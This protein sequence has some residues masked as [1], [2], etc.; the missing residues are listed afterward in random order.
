V[1]ADLP[2]SQGPVSLEERLAPTYRYRGFNA[3]LLLVFAALALLLA[4]IGLYAVIA[5]AVSQRTQEIGIR[6]AVGAQA[7]DI[8]GLVFRQAMLALGIGLTVGLAASL[9][10]NR[11][12]TAQLVDVSPADPVTFVV[13]SVVLILAAALGCLVPARRAMRVDPLVAL[14]SE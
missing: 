13:A 4:S 11:I 12:L 6:L 14:K 8:L 10:V 9:A 7:R 1:D 2:V 3:G 5:H